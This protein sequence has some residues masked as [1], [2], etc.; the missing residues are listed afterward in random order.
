M[1]GA[2]LSWSRE[3]TLPPLL[4]SRRAPQLHTYFLG[5]RRG[6]DTGLISPAHLPTVLVLE[7][8]LAK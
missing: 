4:G 5:V 7:S 6:G 2:E 1:A 3:M 8:V